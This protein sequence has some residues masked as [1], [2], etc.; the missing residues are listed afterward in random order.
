MEVTAYHLSQSYHLLITVRKHVLTDMQP[1]VCTFIDCANSA[2]LFETRSAWYTHEMQVHRK[3]WCCN[4]DDHLPYANKDDFVDHMR[5]SHSGSFSEHQLEDLLNMCQRPLQSTS[6]I[7]PLCTDETEEHVNGQL[8]IRRDPKHV[9]PSELKRHLGH[10]LEQLALF[11]VPP[12]MRAGDED[13]DEEADADDRALPEFHCEDCQSPGGVNELHYC[14][15]C[16][17]VFCQNCWARQITHNP[18]RKF[19]NGM[20][21]ERVDPHDAKIFKTIFSNQSSDELLEELR[22][23]DED[24]TWFGRLHSQYRVG[25]AY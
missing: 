12:S 13:E 10:H 22:A 25:T 5:H 23:E 2:Q 19:R 9:S 21:H 15:M 18:G 4:I 6:S 11:A 16:D 17:C 14:P 20:E 3:E 8:Q 7:C 24:T 1:Y